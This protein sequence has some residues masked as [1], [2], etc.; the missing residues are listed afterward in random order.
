[1]PNHTLAG[2]EKDVRGDE[3]A[4]LGIVVA[5]LQVV[6]L[7]LLVVDVP[8]VAEGVQCAQCGC[9]GARAAQG[10]APAVIGVF[11]HS[12][13]AAVNELNDVSLAVAQVVIVRPVVVHRCRVASGVVAEPQRVVLL[14]EPDQH[15]AVVVIVCNDVVDRLLQSQS[16]LVVAVGN[17]IRPVGDPRQLLPTPGQSLATVGRRVPHGVVDDRLIAVADQLVLPVPGG[18]TVGDRGDGRARVLRRGVGVDTRGSQ[19]PPDVVGIRHRLVGELVVLPDQ[20]VCAVV[21][22]GD[23]GA[24]P[25][26]RG[27]VPVV[28]VGVFIGVVAAVLVRGQQRRL[29]TVI[30][31]HV[32]QVGIVVA[33]KP[34]PPLCDP[35]N[36]VVGHRQHLPVGEGGRHGTV[37]LVVGVDGVPGAPCRRADELRQV[38]VGVVLVL[39]PGQHGPQSHLAAG[40]RERPLRTRHAPARISIR[41]LLSRYEP[42][43]VV[44]QGAYVLFWQSIN[45]EESSPY[46]GVLPEMM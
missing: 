34:Q 45:A 33:G 35:A 11:Y 46:H 36:G 31:R 32:G 40:D 42:Q 7:G 13:F 17:R 27:Y 6:P 16:V 1:M 39:V 15:L 22:V 28:V 19:V 5:G 37:V 25:S 4:G 26:D 9:Q 29:G 43:A 38:V 24:P 12:S 30:P 10:L 14:D 18:I 21:L 2:G 41:L 23:E 3:T 8:T 44:F 20:L